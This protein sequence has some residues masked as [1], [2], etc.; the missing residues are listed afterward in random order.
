MKHP[1]YAQ[2]IL[3]SLELAQLGEG[4]V[5][6]N[7]RV[8]ALLV[9]GDEII[10][11]GFHRQFGGSHAEVMAIASV[12]AA[13][14]HRIHRATLYVSLEPCNFWGKTPPC[15][16]LIQQHG[17][18]KVVLSAMD[19]TPQVN[20]MGVRQ[21]REE[22]I[23]VITGVHEK[24]GNDLVRQR[25]VY[26]EEGRPY[27][28]LKLVL[29]SDGY[30][31]PATAGPFWLSD[32]PTARLTH[33]WRHRTDAILV[34]TKTAIVDNPMLDNRY[35]KGKS[36]ARFV[37][38]KGRS[39]SDG[40]KMFNPPFPSRRITSLPENSE[41]ILVE[42]DSQ[43]NLPIPEI[44]KSIFALGLGSLLVEGGGRLIN[45]F[46]QTAYWDELRLIRTSKLL[47]YGK[48]FDFPLPAPDKKFILGKDF[49]EVYLREKA[50]KP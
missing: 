19:A 32:A 1:N 17:I 9:E 38:D 8:G 27:T 23:E 33:L 35:F 28:I 12:K 46:L 22:G 30:F 36:P 48:Q 20:G 43:G 29:S 16:K 44:C 21:L 14:R 40:L 6:P 10:G 49:I 4:F 11:E 24:R 45:S 5:S 26:V 31:A 39:L 18:R 34:G 47:G 2:Y 50:N 25:T 7:P 3:R 13:N 15:T 37:L 42:T 41:D